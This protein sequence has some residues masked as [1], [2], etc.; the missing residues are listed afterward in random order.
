MPGLM[1]KVFIMIVLIVVIMSLVAIN[2][3][4]CVHHDCIDGANNI[5]N[6]DDDVIAVFVI[7]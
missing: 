3:G 1:V 7:R 6:G 4:K 5:G 2:N